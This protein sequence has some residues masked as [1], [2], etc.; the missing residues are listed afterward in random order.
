M[1]LPF[2]SRF[3]PAGRGGTDAR[4]TGDGDSRATAGDG[5]GTATASDEPRGVGATTLGSG[6]TAL[7]SR[8]KPPTAATPTAATS[9][10]RTAMSASC[11]DG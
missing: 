9:K 10:I 4:S 7:G 8:R 3:A 5:D 2:R 1:A 11:R 6:T